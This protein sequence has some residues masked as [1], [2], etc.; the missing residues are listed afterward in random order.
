MGVCRYAMFVFDNCI[1]NC[2]GNKDEDG[3][4]VEIWRDDSDVLV[5]DTDTFK[6]NLENIGIRNEYKIVCR[7]DTG[8]ST[9]QIDVCERNV[10][11]L[12][13]NGEL[14]T[15]DIE[16]SCVDIVVDW[17]S[18]DLSSKNVNECKKEN[19]VPTVDINM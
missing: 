12:S 10:S 13:G 2:C 11:V 6:R 3:K 19:D 14:W 9:D 8:L 16:I 4:N 5:R 18:I 17:S 1:G 7:T 15:K